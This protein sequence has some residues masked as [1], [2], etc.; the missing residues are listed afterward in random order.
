MCCTTLSRQHNLDF[1]HET[2]WSFVSKTTASKQ[3]CIILWNIISIHLPVTVCYSY[4]FLWLRV[5]AKLRQQEQQHAMSPQKAEEST[6]KPAQAK[7]KATKDPRAVNRDA[8]WNDDIH[9]Y[10]EN[11]Y[12]W[13]ITFFCGPVSQSV[14][15]ETLVRQKAKAKPKSQGSTMLSRGKQSCILLYLTMTFIAWFIRSGWMLSHDSTD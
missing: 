12:I 5:T 6:P 1:V 13:K 11:Y 4:V 3:F 10:L 2:D 15:R 14:S 8:T 9:D 7:A